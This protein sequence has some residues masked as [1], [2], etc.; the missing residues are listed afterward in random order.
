MADAAAK[1]GGADPGR[2]NGLR[3]CVRSVLALGL[4]LDATSIAEALWL[5]AV[6]AARQ[7]QPSAAQQ[8]AV[9]EPAASGA[10]LAATER[11]RPALPATVPAGRRADAE[12]VPGAGPE[13]L[14]PGRRALVGPPRSG[15]QPL[16]LSRAL[17]PFRRR[18]PE[19]RMLQFDID[20]TVQS[21]ARTWKL[22]PRFRPAPER[23]FEVDIV[24]DDS[25]SMTVWGDTIPVV[26]TLLRQLGAFRMIRTWRIS[27]TGPVPLLHNE[28]GQPVGPGQLR[29]PGGRRLIIIV[30]DGCAAGWFRPEAWNLVRTWAGSTPTALISPLATRLWGRT[31]LGLPTGRVGPGVPGSGNAQLQFAVPRHELASGDEPDAGGWLPLPAATL[32]PHMLGRWA[33]MLMKADPRGCDALLIPP[34]RHPPETDADDATDPAAGARLVNAFRR[35]ASPEAGRLAV[36]CAPFRAVSLGLLGLLGAELVPEASAADL[37]EVIVGGLFRPAATASGSPGGE[38]LRFRPGVRERLR[39]L[40]PETDGWRA[41]TALIKHVTEGSGA[42]A[43]FAAGVPDPLGDI[44]IPAGLLPFA[45]ASREA[46]EFLDALPTSWHEEPMITVTRPASVSARPVIWGSV[47]ARLPVF[48]GREQILGELRQTMTSAPP[49]DGNGPDCLSGPTG[50]GKTAVAAEYAH[51]DATDYDI[52]WWVQAGRRELV[53]ASLAALA[54]RLELPAA[55]SGAEDAARAAVDALN[56]G[57]PFG[58]WLLIFDRAE[59]PSDIDDLVP[60]GPGH[61]LITA[62]DGS[63]TGRGRPVPVGPFTRAESLEFLDKRIP[64]PFDADEAGQLAAEFED[65]P[66]ALE[67]AAALITQTGMRIAEYL[68][69][70]R[71][72][73]RELRFDDLGPS[74]YPVALRAALTMALSELSRQ[75]PDTTE[76]LYH[77]VFLDGDKISVDLLRDGA[78]VLGS[79]PG[80]LTETLGALA[81]FGLLSVT[82][83]GTVSVPPLVRALVRDELLDAA[84]DPYP[85]RVHLMLAAVAPAD[86]DDSTQWARFGELRRHLNAVGL[87][88]SPDRRVRDFALNVVRYLR[89]C[90]D[91]AACRSMAMEL[92]DRWRGTSGPHNPHVLQA[93]LQL[94]AALRQSGSYAEAGRITELAYRNARSGLGEQAGVTIESRVALAQDLRLRGDFAD[95]LALDTESRGILAASWGTRDSRWIG[96]ASGVGLDSILTSKYREA[97]D[98][99]S[100][101]FGQ[102]VEGETPAGEIAGTWTRLSWASALCGDYAAAC[103]TAADARDYA[104]ARLAPRHPAIIRA[105]TAL[106]VALRRLGKPTLDEARDLAAEV[107]DESAANLGPGHSDTLAALISLANCERERGSLGDARRLCEQAKA[108]YEEAY[109]PDHPFTYGCGGAI[110]LLYRLMG[111]PAVARNEDDRALD[112]LYRRLTPDHHYSLSVAINLASDLAEL[113]ESHQARVMGEDALRRSRTLLGADHPVTLGCAVNLAADL[114]ADDDPDYAERL[115]SDAMRRYVRAHGGDHPDTKAALAGARINF[116]FDPPPL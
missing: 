23:W 99:L 25:P 100:S 102:C 35:T 91:L 53:S 59:Q 24:V 13:A 41:Y 47:P 18:W 94:A 109:G 115:H 92:A 45:A 89:L 69:R 106:A 11:K 40:L 74:S 77:L 5:A 50:M 46:L 21:Y 61:V 75:Q 20:E 19:G 78:S 26:S 82:G 81:G 2:E 58:R 14:V 65:L 7:E 66:V 83:S 43:T 76:L 84:R 79:D 22:V 63:W 17:R 10:G 71:R 48:T 44:T 86:P 80:T 70:L 49:P 107:L 51:R 103:K 28:G 52:V 97:R 114:R 39:E 15:S 62:S 37:A 12:A 56:R 108:L 88:A 3:R 57:E 32:T 38:L 16:D 27:V 90:G 6:S 110:G 68:E 96:V 42:E 34:V 31:G 8:E 55:D 64:H 113:G 54:A 29:S 4:E 87:S 73:V 101:V 9:A 98:L 104:R 105:T 30:S 85:E 111:D 93:E 36:L 60:R 67:Q 72:E 112:G 1:S 116:D 95:A 33:R